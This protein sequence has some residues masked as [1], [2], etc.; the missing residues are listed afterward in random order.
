MMS[1]GSLPRSATAALMD[2]RST[3]A[4][5]PVRSCS[6]TLAGMNGISLSPFPEALQDATVLTSSSV[7]S[8]PS[9]CLRRDSVS[10]RTEYGI[11][12]RSPMT[13]VFSSSLR[14]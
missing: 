10:T 3:T 8:L 2:A 6:S 12:E 13:P 4:A 7:I 1:S 14:L 11:L 9:L 5:P